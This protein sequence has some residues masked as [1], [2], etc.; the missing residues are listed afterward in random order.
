M[1][2]IYDTSE[3]GFY[4]GIE[5]ASASLTDEVAYRVLGHFGFNSLRNRFGPL[6]E[7]RVC[8]VGC[9]TGGSTIRWLYTGKALNPGSVVKVLGFDL[10]EETLAEARENYPDRPNLFFCRKDADDPI[11]LI[12]DQN[13]HLM[14]APFVLET[15]KDFEDVERLCSQIVDALVEGGEVYFLRLHPNAFFTLRGITPPPGS[16]RG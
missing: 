7:I 15:I 8:D 3:D 10:H 12:E 14:F 13:Y 16:R 11:P 9:Y 5:N 4:K 2:S 6:D 1:T